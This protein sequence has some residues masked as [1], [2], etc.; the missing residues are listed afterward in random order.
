M[1]LLYI[2]FHI[3]MKR[4]MEILIIAMRKQEKLL[5]LFFGNKIQKFLKIKDNGVSLLAII[6]KTHLSQFSMHSPFL[7]KLKNKSMKLYWNITLIFIYNMLCKASLILDKYSPFSL[8][9]TILFMIE[10]MV[11]IELT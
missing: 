3:I 11:K 4:I 2:G 8:L 9:L 1:L 5:K 7:M 6:L 10:R